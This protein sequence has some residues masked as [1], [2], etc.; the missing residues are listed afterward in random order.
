VALWIER[1]IPLRFERYHVR[2]RSEQG[3]DVFDDQVTPA[4]RDAVLV[5]LDASLLPRGRYTLSLEGAA[6][7]GRRVPLS[8]HAFRTLPAPV[9]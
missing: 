3:T 9:R 7:G 2:V 8:Q 5:A 6:R 1:E 4:T